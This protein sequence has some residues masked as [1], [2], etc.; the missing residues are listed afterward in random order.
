MGAP[1]G[2]DVMATS[3][4]RS[5]T[6]TTTTVPRASTSRDGL[7]ED[8]KSGQAL[9]GGA[10]TGVVAGVV[11][12]GVMAVAAVA[13]GLGAAYPLWAVQGLMSGARVI[14]DHPRQSLVAPIPTDWVTGPLYFLL[15]AV[16]VGLLTGWAAARV[17]RRRADEPSRAGAV[18]VALPV[19]ALLFLLFVVVLG[20]RDVEVT[21][22][23]AT[24]GYGVQSLGMAAWVVG[25]VAYV[26]ALLGLLAPV[27]RLIRR[28]LTRR[29]H[30]QGLRGE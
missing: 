27:T 22:Q 13:Q 12:Y 17:R 24:S 28:R 15:P 21:A 29:A 11:M 30:T 20:F 2:D 8:T 3:T 23:R 7:A 4:T 1:R 18:A 26:V 9:L 6:G 10:V 25:H 5:S 14:P 19:T 16:L